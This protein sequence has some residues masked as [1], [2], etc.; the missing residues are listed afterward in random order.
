M[1][2]SRDR[3][4]V[5]RMAVTL[6][7]LGVVACV[8]FGIVYGVVVVFLLGIEV[9]GLLPAGSSV[10]LGF[11][12]TGLVVGP[13]VYWEYARDPLALRFVKTVPRQPVSERPDLLQRTV[14]QL[15][16]HADLPVPTVVVAESEFP[17]A[18]TSGLT[19][20]R[21]TI[22]VTSALLDTLDATER[23]AV[24]AH[25]LAHIKHRDVAVMT[26]ASVPLEMARSIKGWADSKRYRSG[27]ASAW[28]VVSGVFWMLG[29]LLIRALSRYRELAADRGAVTLTGSPVAL[30]SAITKLSKQRGDIPSEDFRRKRGS[31]EAF[32]IVPID[33]PVREPVRI[34][35][36]GERL[37]LHHWYMYSVRKLTASLT[38][39]HPPLDYRLER[40]REIETEL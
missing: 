18:Y 8:F 20:D 31:S 15:A 12:V 23:R 35:P 4:L 3:G 34:G 40:L 11:L 13:I 1:E 32:S 14:E 16:H 6:A 10:W 36:R 26:V 29:R 22:V 37:P 19:P 38:N 9:H 39:T 25:E 33:T 7:L 5:L 30:A 24:L 2:W 21:A 27:G 28:Y 17:T